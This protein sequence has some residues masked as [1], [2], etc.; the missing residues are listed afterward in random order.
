VWWEDLSFKGWLK[1]KTQ[2]VVGGFVLH[3][4]D[5][6]QNLGCGG[7][8][9]PSKGGCRTKPR[10]WWED[11]SFIRWMKDKTQEAAEGFVLN[12]MDGQIPRSIKRFCSAQLIVRGDLF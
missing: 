11:L 1:D 3:R 6:G 4:V 2:D 7:R 12:K 9:C 10:M 8:I 5:E